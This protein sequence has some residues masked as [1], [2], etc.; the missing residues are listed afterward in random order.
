[1]DVASYLFTSYLTSYLHLFSA[2]TSFLRRSVSISEEGGR[3]GLKCLLLS[4]NRVG[5]DPPGTR[6]ATSNAPE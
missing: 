5:D 3:L 2:V 6:I 1:M 4:C